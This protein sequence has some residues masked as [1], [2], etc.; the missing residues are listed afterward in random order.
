MHSFFFGF[1]S[2][3]ANVN[4]KIS[5][6]FARFRPALLHCLTVGW[7]HVCCFNLVSCASSPVNWFLCFVWVSARVTFFPDGR[8]PFE[9]RSWSIEILS[10]SVQFWSSGK[11]YVSNHT[12]NQPIWASLSI[13]FHP[14]GHTHTPC[15]HTYTFLQ[16][17]PIPSHLSTCLGLWYTTS[18]YTLSSML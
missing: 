5:P 7:V 10:F 1:L 13:Y 9:T 4:A 16:P 14:D 8:R 2:V 15:I 12:G 17:H 11:N 18:L 3:W 6:F